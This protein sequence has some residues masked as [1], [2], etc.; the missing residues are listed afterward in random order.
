MMSTVN[1][2][3]ISFDVYRSR[4]DGK[5]IVQ[6]DTDEVEYPCNADGPTGIRIVINDDFDTPIWDN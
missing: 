5:L 2:H 1:E 4:I 6:V 3:I